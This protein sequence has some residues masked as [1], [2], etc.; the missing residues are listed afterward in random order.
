[1]EIRT[2]R[3]YDEP[4]PDDG[5]RVLAD[6][7]WPR[8]LTK[9]RVQAQLWAKDVAPSTELRRWYA[10]DPE[11][12]DEFEARYRA[13]LDTPEGQAA[14]RAVLDVAAPGHRLTL[15]TSAT[16][17]DISHVAVLAR[18]LSALG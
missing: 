6:R 3:V 10:H 5:T 7:L 15:V 17:V 9:E 16:S 18:V 1:V 8:G 4:S 2:K 11:R 12:F 13:E 14:L